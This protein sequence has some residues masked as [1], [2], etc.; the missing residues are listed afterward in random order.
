MHV[1]EGVSYRR[2]VYYQGPVL[3]SQIFGRFVS[4]YY[5]DIFLQIVIIHNPYTYKAKFGS[6]I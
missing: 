2:R 3:T 5:Y 4:V 1:R 6:H